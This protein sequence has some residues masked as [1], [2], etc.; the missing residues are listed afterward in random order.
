MTKIQNMKKI[1]FIHP[2]QVFCSSILGQLF[3][4]KLTE[5]TKFTHP[6]CNMHVC[7]RE[8]EP[9]FGGKLFKCIIIRCYVCVSW[10]ITDW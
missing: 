7:E 8:N 6:N 10:E 5:E 4:V 2:K 1:T 3:E 9:L